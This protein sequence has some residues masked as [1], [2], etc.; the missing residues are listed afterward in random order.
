VAGTEDRLTPP[1]SARALVDA[2]PGARLSEV[3]GA[4]HF[5]QLEEPEAVNR[6][7]RSFLIGLGAPPPAA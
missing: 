4:G 2:I 1:K 7:I 5:P 3:R 6:A